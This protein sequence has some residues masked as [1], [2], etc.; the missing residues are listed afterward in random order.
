[1]WV[2]TVWHMVAVAPPG[3]RLRHLAVALPGTELNHHMTR[4]WSCGGAVGGAEPP[5]SGR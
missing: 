3:T 1:M 2:G 5:A 4:C